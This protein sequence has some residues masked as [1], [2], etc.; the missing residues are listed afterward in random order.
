MQ[1]FALCAAAGEVATAAGLTGWEP[2]AASRAVEVCARRALGAFREDR[3]MMLAVE[4]LYR[5]VTVEAQSFQ[6]SSDQRPVKC[7]GAKIFV[8][9]DGRNPDY[10]DSVAGPGGTSSDITAK[11]GYGP[12][13]PE[14]EEQIDEQRPVVFLFEREPF[15]ECC[16]TASNSAR[17]VA[18]WLANKGALMVIDPNRQNSLIS[19]LRKGA[20]RGGKNSRSG[21]A[22]I[23]RKLFELV[24]QL[25]PD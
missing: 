11:I 9:S 19:R 7:W 18:Q 2:G 14:A 15:R 13:T 3:E 24:D 17:T 21:Y 22:I 6:S 10:T 16:G 20:F 4:K 8:D 5:A 1:R 23:K 25:N 12:L